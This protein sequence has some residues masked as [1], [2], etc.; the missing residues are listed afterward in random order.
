MTSERL[1]R[2]LSSAVLGGILAALAPLGV[3]RAGG[4]QPG[5]GTLFGAVERHGA[6]AS[7][8]ITLRI[9]AGYQN[10]YRGTAWTPVRAIVRNSGGADVSGMLEMPQAGQSASVGAQPDFHGLYQ[11]PMVVPAGGTKQIT[12]YVP[13]ASIQGQVNARFLQGNKTL[14]AASSLPIGVDTSAFLIG[15]LSSAP[16]DMAWVAPAIQHDVTTHVIRLSPGTIDPV[17]QALATFDLIVVTNIDTSQLDRAQLGALRSYVRGGGSIIVIGGPTWQET[18]RPLQT[19]LLPGH[20]SGLRV[21]PNLRGLIPLTPVA[22]PMTSGPAAVSVLVRPSGTILASQAGIPLVVRASEGQGTVE[23]DAFDP[24]LNSIQKWTGAPS[25][26]NHLVAMAAP[27]AITRTW[28]PGGFRARF[29]NVF[30]SEAL[31]GELSNL[32][33]AT[34]PFLALFAALTLVY[35]FILGPANFLLLRRIHREHLAWVTI[36]VLAA[37]FLG[38]ILAILPHVRTG[39]V[40]VNTVGLVTLNG[41]SGSS[42]ATMYVGMATPQG[43]DYQLTYR[44]AALPAP[45]PQLNQANGFSFRSASTLHATP[46]GMRV[47]E[48]PQPAVTFLSMRRWT[49]RDLTLETSVQIPGTVQSGL[50]IDPQ[51]NVVGRIR[52]G[53]NLDLLD[54]VLVAGQTVQHLAAIPAGGSIQARIRPSAATYGQAGTTWDQLYGGSSFGNSDNFGFGGFGDCCNQAAYS[55]ES[56]LLDRIRNVVGMLSQARPNALSTLG[57]VVLVGWTQRPL[58]TLS[59]DGST[60]Q[61]R[62]L[63]VVVTPL[64]VRFPVHGSFRLL[65]GTVG[66]QLVDVLPRAPQSSCCGFGPGSDQTQGASVA[67][68]GFLTFEFDL[69]P[70]GHIRFQ[71]LAVNVSGGDEGVGTG[72]VYDWSTL[73][74][75]PI[76]LSTGAAQLP[77]PNRFVSSQGQIMVRLQ[78]ASGGGD[79]QISDP[80]HDIQISGAGAG[81]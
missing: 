39:S 24:S 44:D 1:G 55:H 57:E 5:M 21:L 76:D 25:L 43:G 48:V 7:S 8:P 70:S 69:P 37:S 61:R 49:M 59:V 18:L 38:A 15:V 6:A 53:T 33:A 2:V 32:P 51:G 79:L 47:Q 20:L 60:P 29:Q 62:D 68:G 73:R 17:P 71:R 36:P 78:A 34:V 52:N 63:S 27:T 66:S 75:V 77:K 74:W 13:G 14:A 46:L 19:V 72:R 23:Y 58:G 16:A 54:P 3:V 56:T 10:I 12:L 4:L 67:S 64:S 9:A 65:S 50:T 26:L 41:S 45:L 28:A 81:T 35:L 31:T 11:E 22:R 42:P 40:V 30:R 80:N